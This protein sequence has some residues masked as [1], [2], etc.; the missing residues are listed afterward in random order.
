[1]DYKTQT[2]ADWQFFVISDDYWWVCL[3]VLLLSVQYFFA[4]GAVGGARAKALPHDWLTEHFGEE[5]KQALNVDI[6]RG[7]YPDNG[8]GRYTMKRGYK[9]W[10]EFN[11]AQRGHLQYMESALQ[12]YFQFLLAGLVY[13]IATA[14]IAAIYLVARIGFQWGYAKYG[15]KGR[16]Y[17]APFVMIIQMALPI[18]TIVAMAQMGKMGSRDV[19]TLNAAAAPVE[20]AIQ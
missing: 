2:E 8:N 16:M 18:Y 15:P 6:P 9:A 3:V 14:S 10:M 12:V 19:A 20:K 7:G 5:H 11:Q 4:V 1:M 13:P 17:A